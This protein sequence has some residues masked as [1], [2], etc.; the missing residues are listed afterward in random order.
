MLKGLVRL[1]GSTSLRLRP[2]VPVGRVQ[3]ST[4]SRLFNKRDEFLERHVGPSPAD[5]EEMV[6][7]CVTPCD[8]IQLLVVTYHILTHMGSCYRSLG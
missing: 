2:Y 7:V 1:S 6:K 8:D 3:L 5:V 4:A